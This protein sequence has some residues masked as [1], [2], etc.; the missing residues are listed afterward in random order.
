V[1]L[2]ERREVEVRREVDEGST[3]DAADPHE[4]MVP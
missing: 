2:R 4:R 1:D 3:E